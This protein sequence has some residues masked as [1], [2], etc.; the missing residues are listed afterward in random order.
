MSIFEFIS[1]AASIVLATGVTKLLSCV[2]QVFNKSRRDWL[3]IAAWLY[4][5]SLHF[6][7]WWRVWALNS[8]PNWDII[9]FFLMMASPVGLSVASTALVSY[10]PH[11][12]DDWKEYFHKEGAR[13]FYYCLVG[14]L[15]AGIIR[16]W[17]LRGA[18]TP[19]WGYISV[20]MCLLAAYFNKRWLQ[21]LAL[22]YLSVQSAA[23]FALSFNIGQHS[24]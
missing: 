23:L 5:T 4:L 10:S 21:A 24:Y 12:I 9:G 7:I 3:H 20:V 11:L 13:I 6:L 8:V 1:V 22:F 18:M 14:V 19:W 17:Y 16:V 2:P 15:L